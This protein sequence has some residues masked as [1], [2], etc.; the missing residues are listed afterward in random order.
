[1]TESERGEER[2]E[3][4]GDSGERKRERARGGRAWGRGS[5]LEIAQLRAE[6]GIS[7]Q[8]ELL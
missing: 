4:G 7:Q 8:A 5:A 3:R 6:F 2:V 1:M